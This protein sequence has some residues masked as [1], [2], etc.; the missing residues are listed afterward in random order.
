MNSVQS[1]QSPKPPVIL[2]KT[3]NCAANAFLLSL[4]ITVLTRQPSVIPISAAVF[5]VTTLA[6]HFWTKGVNK[7]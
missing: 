3:V 7:E 1:I 2:K 4:P 6:A 5:G